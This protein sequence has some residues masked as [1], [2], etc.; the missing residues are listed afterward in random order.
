MVP[1]ASCG[2]SRVP[3]Y[4]G[5]NRASLTSHTRLL[6]SLDSAFQLLILLVIKVTSVGPQ[7]Q[8]TV[9]TW[10]GLL[11]VRSPLLTQSRL[12]SLPELT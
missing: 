7:P 9:V 5:A 3:H 1:P 8:L 12:I 10:F 11:R 2:I 4:S 6:R